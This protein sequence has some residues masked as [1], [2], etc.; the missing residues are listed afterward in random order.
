MSLVDIIQDICSCC[1]QE[2]TLQLVCNRVLCSL[3]WHVLSSICVKVMELGTCPLC[4]WLKWFV[5]LV[6]CKGGA[7]YCKY[8]RVCIM[9]E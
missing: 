1:G 3:W 6:E 4:I 5:V 9:S 8:S 2:V 7:G